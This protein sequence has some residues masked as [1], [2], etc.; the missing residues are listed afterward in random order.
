MP[1]PKDKES[2]LALRDQMQEMKEMQAFRLCQDKFSRLLEQAQGQTE[3]QT[4]LALV[5][6]S[7]GE[8]VAYRKALRC[9]DDLMKEISANIP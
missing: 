9:W 3:S 5:F 1:L 2:L 4:E 7:Q 6:R 8:V